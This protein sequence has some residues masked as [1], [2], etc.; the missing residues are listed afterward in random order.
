MIREGG[1]R[2]GFKRVGRVLL[3]KGKMEVVVSYSETKKG[4]EWSMIWY[5]L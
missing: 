3:L 1:G 2:K 4:E 5:L